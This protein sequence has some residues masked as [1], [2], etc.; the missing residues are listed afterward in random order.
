MV[1]SVELYHDED[2]VARGQLD[3]LARISKKAGVTATF[4]YAQTN[5]RP[6]RWRDLVKWIAESEKEGAVLRP[7]FFPRPVGMFAGHNLSVNPFSLCPSYA[8]LAKLPMDKRIIE[9]RKPDVRERL[10]NELP[11]EAMQ[12]LYAM[13]QTFERMFEVTDP[14]N[15]EPDMNSSVAAI[16]KQRGVSPRE[17]AYDMLLENDGNAMLYLAIAN[18]GDG[19]LNYV[20]E[21]AKEAPFVFAL[22]DGG[23]HYGLICDASYTTFMLAYLTRDRKGEKLPL[24]K[25]VHGL[26]RKPAE[27]VGLLDRG[28]LKPGY[29]ADVNVID[30]TKVQTR[31]PDVRYDLPAGGRR[32]H[33]D[34]VG[35]RYTIVSG[36]IIR[37]DDQAT[38]KLP[39]K[40]VRSGRHT[41]PAQL[42]A[43]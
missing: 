11:A 13:V 40:L 36:E 24:A 15:Y 8:E 25:V 1:P 32:L 43:D 10:I 19:N 17:V 6:N 27:L 33:Q 9:L 12:P 37:K 22:G 5:D 23:A 41:G 21:V 28:L 14:P 39:G 16:A 26:T 20:L 30:Y 3:M 34:A 42:A 18:Y 31:A 4:T 35:Y 29:K 2:K 38:G 7:Q